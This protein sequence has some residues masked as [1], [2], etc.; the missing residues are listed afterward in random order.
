MRSTATQKSPLRPTPLRVPGQSL[1]QQMSDVGYDGILAPV[2]LAMFMTI[3]AGLEWFR[4]E[5]NSKPNPLIFTAGAVLAILYAAVRLN[6]TIK[7]CRRSNT[8]PLR[9]SKS[10]PPG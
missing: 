6:L 10:D 5:M 2:F 1:S 4:F 3:L 7:C 8:D 9:R